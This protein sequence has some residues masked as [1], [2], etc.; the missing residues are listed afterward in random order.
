MANILADFPSRH[1]QSGCGLPSV[2]SAHPL[3]LEAAVSV[4]L[5]ADAPLLMEATS[6][7]VDQFGGYTG[8][9]PKAFRAWAEDFTRKL[10]LPKEKLILGGDHLGPNPWRKES[11]PQAMDK[12]K[13][14]VRQY[15][16]AGF[17][18]IHLDASMALGGDSGPA[19]AQEVVAQRAAE[20]CRASEEAAKNSGGPLPVYVIGTEVPIPGGATHDLADSLEVTRASDALET[21]E[22]HKAAFLKAGLEDAFSRVIA[23]VVQPGVEFGNYTVAFYDR[24]KAR[25]LSAFIAGRGTMVFEAHSTDYQAG[26]ALSELVEDH[27]AILKVGPWLTFACREALF[28][29]EAINRELGGAANVRAAVEAAMLASPGQW[30]SHYHG[31]EAERKL[32]RAFSF[33]DRVRYY[34]PNETTMRAVG[35]LMRE[36]EKREIPLSLLSQYLPHQYEEVREGKLSRDAHSLLKSAVMRVLRLYFKAAKNF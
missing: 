22:T 9:A 14:L 25:A 19:P 33:S 27:Y 5:E 4:A 36:M 20:L 29:L 16:A 31:S 28:A 32:A 11:A 24:E 21:L 2:C 18:K 13:E 23:L 30:Q 10:G 12:A 17:T 8:M 26:R 35:S 34:W 15:A 1:Y 3:C 6:N 7:Q